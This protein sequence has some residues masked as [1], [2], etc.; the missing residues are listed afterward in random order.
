MKNK[1]MAMAIALLALLG[2]GPIFASDHAPLISRIDDTIRVQSQWRGI[3]GVAVVLVEDGAVVWS[4]GYGVADRGSG[5][6]MTPDA[7]MQAASISKSVTAWGVMKLV[8]AGEVSLDDP[9][10]KHLSRWRL[11]PSKFDHNQVTIGRVLS[12]AAG[13]SLHGYPGW[14]PD[15]RLPSLEQSLSGKGWATGGVKVIRSP[16]AGWRYSGG[17][18]TMAQLMIEEVSKE[19]FASYMKREVLDPLGMT[20]SDFN[21]ELRRHDAAATPYG[22]LGA[23]KPSYCFAALAAA[24]LYASANDL[25]KFA[26][27]LMPGPNGEPVGRGVL[28]APTIAAMTT[29]APETNGIYG[30]GYFTRTLPDGTSMV[31]HGGDNR[32]WHALFAVMIEQRRAL[33][34]M[35]NSDRATSAFRK[36]VLREWVDGATPPPSRS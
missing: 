34:I 3:A 32:G 23:K 28:S 14:R 22:V 36:A 1:I 30:L 19:S 31:L 33:V 24:G 6:P 10:E 25:A 16:G 5:T 15:R 21:C 29:P 12:H 7:L 2:S 18:Y 13:L 20:S 11:P 27:A 26:A 9:I 4:Q 17:G 8:E 35:T